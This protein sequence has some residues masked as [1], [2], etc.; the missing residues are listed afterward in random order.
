MSVCAAGAVF[1][2]SKTGGSPACASPSSGTA[3]AIAAAR[4]CA[5]GPGDVE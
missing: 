1:V 2:K 3:C 5:L 4:Y